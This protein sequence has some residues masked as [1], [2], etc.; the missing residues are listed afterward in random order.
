MLN[1]ITRLVA[2]AVIIL[3][4]AACAPAATPTP[5]GGLGDEYGSGT[6]GVLPTPNVALP[7]EA[8]NSLQFSAA[9]PMTIDPS[10]FYMATLKTA[11]GD[12]VVELL[13]DKAPVTVNNF[14]FLA[15]QG[16]YDQTTFHRVLD[17]FMAQGGDPTGTGGG[18]PGYQF[19]DEIHPD[20]A[21]DEPGLLAMANSGPDSNG[22]QFFI[23]F[24]PTP[25][26]NGRHTIFGRVLSGMDV[27]LALTRRDPDTAPTFEGDELMTVEIEETAQSQLPPPT[28][29]P[30]PVVPVVE[31]GRPLAA[32]PIADRANLYTGK[33]AMVI[34]P[35]KTY[36]ATIETSKG[37]ITLELYAADAPEAVNNF[38]V[39]AGLGYWDAFPIIHAEPGQF[40][41]TGSP[42][43]QPSSDVGYTLPTETLR[44]NVTGAVGYWF[45]EDRAASSGSQVYILLTDAPNMDGRFGVFG[46]VTS[47]LEIAQQLTNED[48]IDRI[49]IEE[50]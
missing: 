20:L 39:L 4:L 13:A 19:A 8:G 31:D 21:F 46:V 14:V 38:V 6:P 11:K 47:G 36:S 26:L 16:Y 18:G 12:I 40:V 1:K 42:G 43:G 35:S 29:T 48:Q 17:N 7:T 22:S 34:D 50:R 37:N 27:A 24:V 23:T 3:L 15:R 9:P 10:K 2:G 5:T 30:I 33:P 44:P 28:A 49:T 45:R 41:L 25:H 32:L